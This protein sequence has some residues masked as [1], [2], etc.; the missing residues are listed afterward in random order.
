MTLPAA[1]F[2]GFS[3]GLV[4]ACQGAYKDTLWEPFE[5]IKFVRSLF[6]GMI[7]GVFWYLFLWYLF[8]TTDSVPTVHPA[9]F[10][11][12]VI[13]FDSLVTEAYKRG[14]RVENLTRYKMPTIFHLNG[15]II[16]NRVLRASVSIFLLLVLI[17]VYAA[18]QTVGQA[19]SF[20]AGSWFIGLLGGLMAGTLVA[21]GG[22][23]LDSAWEGF[24]TK[25][26]FRSVIVG[27]YWGVIFSYQ[28]SSLPLVVFG[29][30]GMDRMSIEFY[31]TFIRK[32]RS[33]KFKHEQPTYLSWL[34]KRERLVVPYLL[35]W[36]IFIYLLVA[37]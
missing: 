8:L 6:I 19:I 24:S 11:A 36:L 2:L 9:L 10:L 32:M 30:F 1:L 35:N 33:A 20:S 37:Y 12:L 13:M 4:R 7:G 18:F 22:A 28:S 21:S 5:K 25:K 14:F 26:F 23:L 16:Q 15:H 27:G 31:K 3:G 34:S 29:C 17:I